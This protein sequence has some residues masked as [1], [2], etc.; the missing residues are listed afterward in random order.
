MLFS[1]LVGAAVGRI[2]ASLFAAVCALPPFSLSPL[3]KYDIDMRHDPP[4][5]I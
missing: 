4:R 3:C 1:K 2:F 5:V